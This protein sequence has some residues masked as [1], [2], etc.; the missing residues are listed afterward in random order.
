MG[1][2]RAMARRGHDVT[3]YTTNFNGADDL[4]VPLGVPVESGGVTVKYF[5]VHA[6]RFWETCLP[7]GRALR[8]DAG[9]FD[10]MHLHSLYMYH[11][12]AGAAAARRAG[13]PYIVRPHGTLDPYIFKRRRTRKAI[14]EWWFQNRVLEQAAALH[15]TTED[16]WR[17]AA[18]VARN[19]HGFVVPNGLDTDE[20]AHLPADGAFRAKHPEI[21][22]RAI[23]L[24]LGRLNFKKGLDL[25]APAFGQV[26]AAGHDA[27]LVIAGPDD[28][29]AEK[30]RVWLADA[31]ALD[32]TTF[33]GMITGDEKLSALV[34][35]SMFVL[36]SYSENFGIAVA[37][38]MACGLP[39]VISDAVNIWPE[40]KS[41]EAGLVG[42]CDIEATARHMMHVLENP[43]RAAEMGAA[44]I[45]LVRDRYSWDGIAPT[46]EKA[47]EDVLAGRHSELKPS[48]D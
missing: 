38:A 43:G 39:V 1:M 45:R 34:D 17:L 11:D 47:Y 6:P 19:P 41:A 35:A 20:F 15:Y 32:R 3:I 40:V 14:F 31:N 26:L 9:A 5:P 48:H 46:L 10:L 28:D 12:R 2:S 16:E 13:I 36:P 7:L 33:T 37:E 42:P 27:H 8:A 24:F 23:I 18:P 29:M 44:G 4:D 21:G 30:T 25:L 22:D